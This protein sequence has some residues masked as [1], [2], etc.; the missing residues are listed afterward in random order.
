MEKF[1]LEGAGPVPAVVGVGGVKSGYDLAS[2]LRKGATAV[3]VSS[4]L[5]L[6][7]PLLF[8]R[9]AREYALLEGG[10]RGVR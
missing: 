6:E 9:L 8:E 7:G 4:D 2:A 1:F 10:K 5:A 3:Q